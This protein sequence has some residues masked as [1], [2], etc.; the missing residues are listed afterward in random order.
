[1]STDN[2]RL[3]ELESV[4]AASQALASAEQQDA[5]VLHPIL[6]FRAGT[7]LFGAEA[8]HVY[9]VVISGSLTPVPTARPYVLGI[10]LV[11]GR[12]VP[13]ISLGELLGFQSGDEAAPTLPRL[14]IVRQGPLEVT[15][16]SDATLGLF[17]LDL[18]DLGAGTGTRP[19]CIA[20]ELEFRGDLLLLLAVPELLR[21][22]TTEGGR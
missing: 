1:M 12:V 3:R 15:V 8:H 4:G 22:L 17:D 20:G 18:T 10:T 9:E 16:L 5:A 14:L 7:R 19:E 21:S 2:E 13:V 6:V 11:R